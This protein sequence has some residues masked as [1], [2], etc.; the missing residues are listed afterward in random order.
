MTPFQLTFDCAD[1]TVMVRFWANA[2]GYEAEPAP[3]GFSDWNAYWRSAGVS[4]EKPVGDGCGSIVDPRGTG[5]RIWFQPVPEG[6]SVKNRL[7]LDIR[8]SGGREVPLAIRKERIDAEVLRLVKA[9]ATR[10]RVLAPED[11]D[12]YAVVMQDPEGN[13]FCLA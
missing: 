13:E 6:K 5:P 9:G 7:H 1:P 3:T 12:H 4:E 10:L 2:L 11:H 8:A